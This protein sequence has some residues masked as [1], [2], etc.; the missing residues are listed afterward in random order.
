MREP[1]GLGIDDEILFVCDG[2]D[3]LLVYEA[4]DLATI[5]QKKIAHFPNIDAYDV[6]PFQDYLF[7]I[8]DD[9]FYQY[10]YSN[11]Q[12]VYE[13]SFIPVMK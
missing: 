7:M 4:S 11:L 3:G 9:G 12:N 8:G 6:I 1:Y 5:P 2:K 13:V 10:D